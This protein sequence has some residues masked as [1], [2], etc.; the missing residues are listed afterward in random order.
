MREGEKAQLHTGMKQIW[1]IYSSLSQF[2]RGEKTP[3][4]NRKGAYVGHEFGD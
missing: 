2:I 4:I 3:I 1:V